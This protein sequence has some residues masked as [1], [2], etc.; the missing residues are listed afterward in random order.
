MG[1]EL[2]ERIAQT[3][4]EQAENIA[5]AAKDPRYRRAFGQVARLRLS[6]WM[7]LVWD[8]LDGVHVTMRG[9]TS[10]PH[11]CVTFRAPGDCRSTGSICADGSLCGEPMDD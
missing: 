3:R 4:R 5:A 10:G 9:A 6:G 7:V 11:L 1:T 2:A 8:A